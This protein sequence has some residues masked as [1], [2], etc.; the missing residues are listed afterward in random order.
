MENWLWG[1]LHLHW[2]FSSSPVNLMRDKLD[3]FGGFCRCLPS[4]ED[5]VVDTFLSVSNTLSSAI[6][7]LSQLTY[8]H[9]S[10]LGSETLA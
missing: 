5:L 8:A 1:N 4:R 6:A 3:F 7:D 9:G 10:G 2:S